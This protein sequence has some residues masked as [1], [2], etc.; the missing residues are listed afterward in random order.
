MLEELS[1]QGIKE[2]LERLKEKPTIRE[3]Q[4]QTRVYSLSCE[5]GCYSTGCDTCDQCVICDCVGCYS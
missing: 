4:A 3:S 5:T 2:S 1:E